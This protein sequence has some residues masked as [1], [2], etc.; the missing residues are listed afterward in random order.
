MA[1]FWEKSFIGMHTHL[2][3]WSSGRIGGA[4]GGTPVLL[5]TTMG[6]KTGRERTTPLGYF[7]DGRDYI[8]VASNG[9]RPQ[10]PAWYLNLSQNPQVTIRIREGVRPAVAATVPAEQQAELWSRVAAA[11]PAYAPYSDP[12]RGIPLVRLRPAA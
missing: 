4:I 1:S 7:K 11:A 8:V 9:G 2:Y 6:R 10:R 12:A 5:L 3:R